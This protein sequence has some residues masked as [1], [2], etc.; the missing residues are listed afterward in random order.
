M[1]SAAPPPEV[2]V[3]IAD[4]MALEPA[5]RGLG[6]FSRQPVRSILAGQ[7]GS[8]LRGRG[9]DFKELRRYLPGD[10]L[11]QLDWRASQRL[12]K[13]YVRTYSEERD[14]PSLVVVDQRMGMYFGSVRN[15]KSVVAARVAALSAWM[16]FQA[17]DRV[18]GLVF[19]DAGM[20]SVR[21]LRSR[22]RIQALFAAIA[23]RSQSMR[24]DQP[25]VD[26]SGRLNQAL[27]GALAHAP[28]DCLVCLISDFAGADDT[29]LRL[30]RTLA[31]HNDVVATLVYDPLALRIPLRGR[32][33]V[34]QGE[35]QVEVAADRK[36]VREPLSAF[37][38]GRLHDV[39]ELLRRS[40]V[41]LLSIDTAEDTATQL[42]RELGRQASR[43]PPR[44]RT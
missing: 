24:A 5:A 38:S 28:H 44:E 4:L 23:R 2:Q 32:L 30:L 29:T 39:A 13:P 6:F 3:R 11:R 40:R 22:E 18:G 10:D 20:D 7:H 36:Q 31:A 12:G 17:G 33:V 15:F 27:E 34:T 14:R 25:D 8:R 35:L 16:A 1:A 26:A 9:L 21:P 43:P 19:S 41:P 37:F 42:R